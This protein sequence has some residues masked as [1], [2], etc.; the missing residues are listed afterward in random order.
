MRQINTIGICVLLLAKGANAGLVKDD[1][2]ALVDDRNLG[3]ATLGLGAAGV[4]H[5][6]DDNAKDGLERVFSIGSPADFTNIYGASSFNLPM[7]FGLWGS[8]LLRTLAL[9]Q[10][11]V[12]PIKFAVRRE[13][14]DGSNRRSFPSGHTAN[15]F[16]IARLLHRSYGRP[17]GIPLYLVAGFVGAGRIEHDRHFF[18]DVVMGAV[19]GT[20]VGNSVTLDTDERLGVVP[21]MMGSRLTLM[22]RVRL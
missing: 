11:V 6:W 10:L 3:L 15:G 8:A 4:A 16:A 21:V 14:P 13:R 1:F 20:I 18:S 7:S 12:G 19:L 22:L 17:V 2:N 5:N 9:T